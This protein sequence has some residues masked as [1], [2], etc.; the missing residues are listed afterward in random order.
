MKTNIKRL[1]VLLAFAP[2]AAMAS[3]ADY[4]GHSSKPW[5]IQEPKETFTIAVFADGKDVIPTSLL[6]SK[7][8]IGQG[9]LASPTFT[10]MGGTG[11]FGGKEQSSKPWLQP[12]RTMAEFRALNANDQVAFVC[13]HCKTTAYAKAG[14]SFTN[15]KE[16]DNSV[17]YTCD[18]CG[19]EGCCYVVKS[20]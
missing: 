20:R 18:V 8:W 6:T 17:V 9:Q 5:L 19:A 15:L 7:P 16:G 2:L 4:S 12:I 1:L 10:A 11:S 13:P 14:N 3:G